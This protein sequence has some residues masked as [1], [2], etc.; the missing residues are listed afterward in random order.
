MSGQSEI[1]SAFQEARWMIDC[2]QLNFKKNG[3]DCLNNGNG[4]TFVVG[5]WRYLL[6]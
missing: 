3:V 4:Q 6:R 5:L 2:D 1:S